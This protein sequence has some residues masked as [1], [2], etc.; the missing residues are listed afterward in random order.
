MDGAYHKI[1]PG[2]PKPAKTF[3]DEAVPKPTE[4]WNK[5][6]CPLPGPV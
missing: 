6:R 5:L 4:F 3:I 2:L 1:N